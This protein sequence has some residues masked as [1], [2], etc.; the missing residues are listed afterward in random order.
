MVYPPVIVV[1]EKDTEIGHAML[2]EVWQK[3][4]YHRNVRVMVEDEEGNILIQRRSPQ[5][6][7]FPGCWDNSAAGHVDQH[8]DYLSAA[9]QE[10][11]EEIGI[12]DPALM[13]VGH[14]FMKGETAG[15]KMYTF[16]MAYKLRVT[17]KS[18]IVR[19]PE[20]V[21][22]LKWVS[23]AE[24]KQLVRERPDSVTFGLA[25]VAEHYY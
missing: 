16:N 14:F 5:M 24:L 8:M 13:E 11:A 7:V 15:R 23:P 6:V 17:D 19:E 12:N 1:D 4:L 18:S 3:G 25:Y 22:E 2:A 10:V 9:R 20:E 21:S